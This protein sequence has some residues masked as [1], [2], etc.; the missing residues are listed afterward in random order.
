MN[1]EILTS[2]KVGTVKFGLISKNWKT[3]K[4]EIP[5]TNQNKIS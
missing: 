1:F 2:I 5:K 3:I 4:I